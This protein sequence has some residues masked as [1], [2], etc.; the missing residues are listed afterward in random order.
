[1]PGFDP[2]NINRVDQCYEPGQ[3]KSNKQSPEILGFKPATIA[4]PVST[5]FKSAEKQARY[6]ESENESDEA[7]H[8]VLVL[9]K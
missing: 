4:I 5:S 2:F 9:I 3:A 7:D 6:G 8:F 1:M